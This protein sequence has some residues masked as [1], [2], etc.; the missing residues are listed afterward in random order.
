MHIPSEFRCGT[1]A[2]FCSFCFDCMDDLYSIPFEL[3]SVLFLPCLQLIHLETLQRINEEL[4]FSNVIIHHDSRLTL[5]V[6]VTTIDA[7]EHL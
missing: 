5:K 3:L 7:Q 4:V 2:S 1:L 6:L